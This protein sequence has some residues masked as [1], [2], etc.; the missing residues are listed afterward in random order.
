MDLEKVR[1]LE[2]NAEIYGVQDRIM[3][4]QMDVL[5]FEGS[6]FDWA[7]CSPPWGGIGYDMKRIGL[8]IETGFPL[9]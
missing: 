3:V 2:I 4:H 6:A 8:S 7:Y 9:E 5:A 1:N